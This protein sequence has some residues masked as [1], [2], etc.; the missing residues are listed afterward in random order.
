MRRSRRNRRRR[1]GW[2]S[3]EGVG[4]VYVVCCIICLWLVFVLF[5]G[6]YV[7]FCCYGFFLKFWWFWKWWFWL[8]FMLCLL[9]F[10]LVFLGKVLRLIFQLL[11]RVQLLSQSYLGFCF[12]V[13]FCLF[14]R[15]ILCYVVDVRFFF[16]CSC[17]CLRLFSYYFLLVVGDFFR[18]WVGLWLFVQQSCCLVSG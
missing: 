16:S 8:V 12:L 2:W 4:F 10:Y 14:C 7:G 9:C 17:W 11:V 5:V 18:V 13:F 6:V 15:I 3:L 1:R